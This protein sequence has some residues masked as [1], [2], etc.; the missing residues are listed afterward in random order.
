MNKVKTF[1]STCYVKFVNEPMFLR[2]ILTH[3][4]DFTSTKLYFSV[5][6]RCNN[7]GVLLVI[8]ELLSD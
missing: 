8:I 5:G 1:F 7:R 6:N 4:L 3:K 2:K